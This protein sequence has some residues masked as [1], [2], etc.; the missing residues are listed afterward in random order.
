MILIVIA[1]E[2][3]FPCAEEIGEVCVDHVAGAD[4]GYAVPPSAASGITSPGFVSLSFR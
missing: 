3:R 2:S 4:R 1:H